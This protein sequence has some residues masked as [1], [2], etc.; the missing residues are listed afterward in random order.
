M[1]PKLWAVAVP[2]ATALMLLAVPFGQ[3]GGVSPA[4]AQGGARAVRANPTT[5][6]TDAI[7]CH[8]TFASTKT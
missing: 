6:S 2:A 8:S 3:P 4:C 5:V 1:T 7:P